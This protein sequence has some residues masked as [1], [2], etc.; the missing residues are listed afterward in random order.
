M[1]PPA[2]QNPKQHGYTPLR[3]TSPPKDGSNTREYPIN[4][5]VSPGR[6]AQRNATKPIGKTSI[7]PGQ[8]IP[9]L[10]LLCSANVVWSFAVLIAKRGL[11]PAPGARVKDKFVS[12]PDELDEAPAQ[13]D[14]QRTLDL[15]STV[16]EVCSAELVANTLPLEI[17]LVIMKHSDCI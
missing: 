7:A 14:R 5:R 11:Q 13:L 1:A 16:F 10:I 12:L 8:V 6:P 17:Y 15:P 9:G 4:R 3:A 2:A